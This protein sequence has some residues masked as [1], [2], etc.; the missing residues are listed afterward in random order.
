[1]HYLAF[2]ERRRS[3]IKKGGNAAGEIMSR[4]EQDQQ[5]EA[6]AA[7]L[8]SQTE[9][10]K[11]WLGKT[12][13]EIRFGT[14]LLLEIQ[15]YMQ[16]AFLTAGDEDFA[17]AIKN[18][19]TKYTRQHVPTPEETKAALIDKIMERLE[20]TNNHHWKVPHNVQTERTK[21]RFWDVAALTQ[22]L[23][24]IVRAQELSAKSP[25]EIREI[26]YGNKEAP[27]NW[28]RLPLRMVPRGQVTSIAIDADH[29]NNLAKNDKYEFVRLCKLFGTEQIDRRRGIR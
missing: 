3:H 19:E 13:P 23:D 1:M 4:F 25:V 15:E 11:T 14:A 17:Y 22:R 26:A 10:F 9:A 29:L 2:P 18:I 6:H 8:Q 24:G 12:H 27:S 16:S 21:M 20:G 5:E 28:P 7:R